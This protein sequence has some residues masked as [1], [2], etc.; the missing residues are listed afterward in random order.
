MLAAI[1][2]FAEF[3]LV[4][5]DPPIVRRV[6]VLGDM[7][8]LG[9][10]APDAH[11]EIGEAAAASDGFDLI[12]FVGPLS[13]FAAERAAKTLGG[14]RVIAHAD[15]TDQTIAAVAGELR[16]GDLVLLKASRRIALERVIKS[17]ERL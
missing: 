9:G 2:T 5:F 3:A 16:A 17:L 10:A 14:D 13:M 8:E 15:F 6:G 4:P 7:L 1:R 12:I 11:R